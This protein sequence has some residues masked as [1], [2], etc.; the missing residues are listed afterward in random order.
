MGAA[1]GGGREMS[2]QQA[3]TGPDP[4]ATSA[5]AHESALV[6]TAAFRTI[7]S[8]RRYIAAHHDI[9]MNE[10]RALTRIA[11]GEHVTPGA[12]AESLELTT[13]S[14][15]SLIDRLESAKLVERTPHPNDRRSLQLELTPAGAAKVNAVYD[16]F[17]NQVREAVDAVPEEQVRAANE[18]LTVVARTVRARG[19]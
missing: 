15:T 6:L 10:V 18:Y 5:L 1:R 7:D 19:A 3:N 4:E 16:A 8:F 17:E 13:G 11:E 12:L 2:G 9:G 14:V